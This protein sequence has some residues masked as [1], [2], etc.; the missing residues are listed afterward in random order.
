M[1][2]YEVI[3]EKI[4]TNTY[5]PSFRRAELSFDMNSSVHFLTKECDVS[6]LCRAAHRVPSEIQT[7]FLS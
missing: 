1:C 7:E 3:A 2:I 6:D 4:F 5:E